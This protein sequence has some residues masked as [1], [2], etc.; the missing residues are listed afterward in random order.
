MSVGQSLKRPPPPVL[1]IDV[2]T[3]WI[4]VLIGELVMLS[5]RGDP[6]DHGALGGR[7]AKGG[8]SRPQRPAALKASVREEPMKAHRDAGAHRHV[9][10]G[11]EQQV[12][13]TEQVSA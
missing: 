12:L 7:R 10:E 3:V 8:E 5:M 9:H 13:P 2:R 11:K 6:V 1:A 4:A